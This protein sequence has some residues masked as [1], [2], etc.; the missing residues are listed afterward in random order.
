VLQQPSRPATL[1]SPGA[2]RRTVI[3]VIVAMLLVPLAGVLL[4]RG[5][6]P[7]APVARVPSASLPSPIEPRPVED[8]TPEIRGRILDADGDAVEG[9]TVRLVSPTAP[10]TGLRDTRSNSAG[11]FSFARVSLAA[12]RVVADHDIE[13]SVVSAE[14]LP[15]EGQSMDVTLVLARVGAIRGT[16][17]DGHDHP[18][19]GAALSVEG[20]PWVIR[21][22]TSDEAGGFLLPAV[23]RE[24]TSLVAV[25]QGF[26]TARVDL[27]HRSDDEL[28]L[29]V[30]LTAAPPIDGDVHDVDGQ[31]VH[32]RI[33]ACE[34]QASEAR[35]DS[36]DDGTFQLPPST[37]GCD[38]VA[39]HDEYAP[40]DTVSVIAGRRLALRLK[41][42][43][44]IE[45][46][47]VDD[48]GA[49][50]PSFTVGIESFTAARGRSFRSGGSRHFDDR[51]GAFR[52]DRLAP[53]AYVL[54][55]SA[56]GAPPA[57]SDSI[58]VR[59]GAVTSDVRI[60]LGKGGTVTGHVYDER[61]APVA[62]VDLRFDAVSSAVGT[63]AN[64]KSDDSGEYRLEGA[65]TGLFTLRAQKDGF[66][67]RLVSGLRVESGST[68]AQDV[69]LAPVAGG[70][71][72][73]FA[74]I[75]A[76]LSPG[77]DGIAL[78]SVMTG[79]PAERAGLR[80][81]DR[82]LRI[83]GEGTDGLSVADVMQRLRG[84]AG[85]SVGITVQRPQTG[86]T[87]DVVVA[88]AAIVY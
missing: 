20:A 54:S 67:V 23:P 17:V 52:F 41:P 72:T 60:T 14:I 74:G 65:P 59:G 66:R 33:V 9:A 77:R 56:P 78:G 21:S 73:E 31:P 71:G 39:Q 69:T 36:S 48:H 7:R 87:I 38:V 22:A 34:G 42:G 51:T 85:T 53:G 50:V 4:A 81:G 61:H 70:G 13:G 80:A 43:G 27:S 5:L 82:I 10:Y 11:S 29:R 2:A 6:S 57:R 40:S 68:L 86:E 26:E 49:G 79:Q 19:A 47:V 83:D 12:V 62:G 25:A 16:V 3:V 75:G 46:S 18:V 84:E 24:A 64:A 37:I 58:E 32:A 30:K 15:S 63:N 76:S 8:L 35:V 55:A 44:S 88:R 45:G 1:A 28:V